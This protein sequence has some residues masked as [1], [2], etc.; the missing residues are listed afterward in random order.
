QAPGT[1]VS[2][3]LNNDFTGRMWGRTGCNTS[4]SPAQ[5]TTGQCGGTGL[6]CAGTTGFPNTSLFEIN[7]DANGTDWYNVSYVDAIDNPIGV[8]VS[9]PS[10]TSPNTC[11][12]TVKDVC[13]GDL[14]Q[15][16]T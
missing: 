2:F 13:P 10:C 16:S 12:S 4:T 14:R 3:T 5:C 9:N 7:V 8:Q 1:S 11:S 6:Q 15:G